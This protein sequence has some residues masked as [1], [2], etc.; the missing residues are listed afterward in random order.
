[1]KGLIL[2]KTRY[3]LSTELTWKKG[4]QRAGEWRL[5]ENVGV[6]VERWEGGWVKEEVSGPL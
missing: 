4:S 1:M 3:T 5:W 2:S 6:G